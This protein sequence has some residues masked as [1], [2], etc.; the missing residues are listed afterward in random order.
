MEFVFVNSEKEQL[1]NEV[2]AGE[3]QRLELLLAFNDVDIDYFRKNSSL[4][5]NLIKTLTSNSSPMTAFKE[6][7]KIIKNKIT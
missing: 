2:A 5:S 1:L 7:K 4:R 6:Y 3:G